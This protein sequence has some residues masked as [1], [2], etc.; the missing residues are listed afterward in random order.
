MKKEKKLS[1]LIREKIKYLGNVVLITA[2]FM[3]EWGKI[4]QF[5]DATPSF[6]GYHSKE[7]FT[8]T[9]VIEIMPDFIASKHDLFVKKLY[10][11][12]ESRIIRKFRLTLAKE[13]KGYLFP[14]KIYV[15]YFLGRKNDLCFQALILKISTMSMFMM[16]DFQG[17][18]QG[19]DYPFFKKFFRNCTGNKLS[20]LSKCNIGLIMPEILEKALKL[21]EKPDKLV[22]LND[23]KIDMYLPMRLEKVIQSFEE[24]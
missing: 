7:F 17:Q 20:I 23:V 10:E 14:I 11:T 12:G 9:N 19:L 24:F 13:A 16:I 3:R 6:F 4:I 5:S 15:N 2:S 22:S 8:I 18:I 21:E 1:K